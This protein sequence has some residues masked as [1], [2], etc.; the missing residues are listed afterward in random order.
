MRFTPNKLRNLLLESN[1]RLPKGYSVVKRKR[2]LSGNMALSFLSGDAS[3]T[4]I[5]SLEARAKAM[6][7]KKQLEK[8]EDRLDELEEYDELGFIGL[9]EIGSK[10][11]ERQQ[12]RQE[13]KE[14]R[15]EKRE[16]KRSG[17]AT[18]DPVIDTEQNAPTPAVP[19]TSSRAGSA[20]KS[21]IPTSGMAVRRPAPKVDT[22]KAKA[23]AP[24]V[25]TD[26]SAANVSLQTAKQQVEEARDAARTA[27]EEVATV[28]APKSFFAGKNLIIIGAVAVAALGGLYFF[29]KKK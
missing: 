1:Y 27:S 23:P 3:G 26:R 17:P 22:V 24:L 7:A 8:A 13:K 4:G 5:E 29:S 2:S 25:T 18:P 10:K 19:S 16:A 15:Q 9:D 14:V 20:A 21:A 28:E 11:Q 6:Y 12:K